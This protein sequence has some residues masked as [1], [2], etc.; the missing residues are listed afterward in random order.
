MRYRA[1]IFLVLVLSLLVNTDAGELPAN[2]SNNNQAAE[3]A[4]RLAYLT[5]RIPQNLWPVY[6]YHGLNS[7]YI[8]NIVGIKIWLRKLNSPK[9]MPEFRIFESDIGA[10]IFRRNKYGNQ[11]MYPIIYNFESDI[12]PTEFFDP[13]DV[14][15]V[16]IPA[17]EYYIGFMF[18]TMRGGS[19]ILQ[20]EYFQGSRGLV[21]GVYDI[22]PSLIP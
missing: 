14:F 17:G 7:S 6:R 3:L 5:I 16:A 12:G 10:V 18:E 21:A 1:S 2:Q 8:E 22:T 15:N 11:E 19:L 20:G 4:Q 13:G 9:N